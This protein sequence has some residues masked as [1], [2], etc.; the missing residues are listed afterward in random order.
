[1]AA[2]RAAAFDEKLESACVALSG[3]AAVFELCFEDCFDAG[4]D[5]V[6]AAEKPT[7]FG[8]REQALIA[9]DGDRVL[10]V[11]RESLAI[12]ERTL[13]RLTVAVDERRACAELVQQREQHGGPAPRMRL[14]N[15]SK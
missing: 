7:A 14:G 11:L 12:F 6:G 3:V 2:E 13:E 4:G 5:G 8:F 15:T 10:L 9:R 1:M